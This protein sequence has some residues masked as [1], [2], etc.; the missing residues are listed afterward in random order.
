MPISDCVIALDTRLAEG[1]LGQM[2][3]S[4]ADGDDLR[5]QE[6]ALGDPPAA[7]LPIDIE[8][9]PEDLEGF[10]PARDWSEEEPETEES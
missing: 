9:D 10:V 5:G 4:P 7:D 6:D 1:Y 3:D 2:T 8:P